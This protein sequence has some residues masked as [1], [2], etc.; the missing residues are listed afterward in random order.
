MTNTYTFSIKELEIKQQFLEKENVVF[1][2]N[3]KFEGEDQ[4]GNKAYTTLS[5]R[6]NNPTENFTPF[7]DLTEEIIMSWI[8]PVYEHL[9]ERL[10]EQVDKKLQSDDINLISMPIPWES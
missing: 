7:E 8:A 5:F 4:N 2:V 9:E 1:R 3:F 6:L 10:K